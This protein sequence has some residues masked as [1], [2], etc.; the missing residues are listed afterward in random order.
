MR[1]EQ[2]ET[3]AVKERTIRADTRRRTRR[4]IE[5]L[6]SV[7]LLFVTAVLLTT[8]IAFGVPPA[9]TSARPGALVRI[10]NVPMLTR[11]A[12]RDVE[13]AFNLKQLSALGP[14]SGIR[15]SAR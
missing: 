3:Y 13:Q 7:T 9:L 14:G 15:E 8:L 1:T 2:A 5:A 4:E 11:L 6:F 12:W 10:P